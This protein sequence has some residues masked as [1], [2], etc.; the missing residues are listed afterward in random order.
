VAVAVAEAAV[1]VAEA[2][3][4]E[5]AAGAHTANIADSAAAKG[6]ALPCW[7]QHQADPKGLGFQLVQ[8]GLHTRQRGRSEEVGDAVVELDLG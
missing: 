3:V 6:Q 1:A 8:A 4:A 7:D 2:A 5:V